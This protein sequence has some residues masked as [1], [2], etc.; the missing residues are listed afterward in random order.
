MITSLPELGLT[1]NIF[2]LVGFRW[3]SSGKLYEEDSLNFSI[4]DIS[5]NFDLDPLTN[6]K[7]SS[8]LTKI[9]QYENNQKLSSDKELSFKVNE[10]RD[11][12]TIRIL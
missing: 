6:F 1:H 9:N 11:N 8:R 3:A 2:F 7:S 4:R 10:N 5:I 12:N